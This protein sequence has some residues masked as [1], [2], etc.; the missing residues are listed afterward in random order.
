MLCLSGSVVNRHDVLEEGV[1]LASTVSL[2]GNPARE[3]PRKER[4]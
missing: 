1:M 4:G 2:A 3:V